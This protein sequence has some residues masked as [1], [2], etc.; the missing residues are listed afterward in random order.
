MAIHASLALRTVASL[1]VGGVAFARQ[2][3]TTS[4]SAA[5]KDVEPSTATEKSMKAANGGSRAAKPAA[6]DP[7][8]RRCPYMKAEGLPAEKI[9]A[10]NER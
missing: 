9:N 1:F 2:T 7:V 4:G 6:A 10:C 8:L 3:G 5:G